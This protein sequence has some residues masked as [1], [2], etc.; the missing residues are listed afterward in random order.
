MYRVAKAHFSTKLPQ[1]NANDSHLQVFFMI[2]LTFFY[3]TVL[4]VFFKA[5]IAGNS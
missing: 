4:L 2:S 1:L 5:T 3:Q